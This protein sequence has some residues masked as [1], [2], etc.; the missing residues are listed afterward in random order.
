MMV[1]E[2]LIFNEINEVNEASNNV[3]RQV[4]QYK[5]VSKD[6][7]LMNKYQWKLIRLSFTVT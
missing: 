7:N 1:D 5:D 2:L 3:H 4:V 6:W